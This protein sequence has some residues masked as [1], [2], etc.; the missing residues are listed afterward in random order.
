MTTIEISS[1]YAESLWLQALVSALPYIGGSV[2]K[3][4]TSRHDSIVKSRIEY[5][6]STMSDRIEKL[7]VDINKEVVLTEEFHDIL[8]N[9]LEKVTKIGQKERIKAISSILVEAAAGQSDLDS[10][11]PTDLINVLAEL[12]DQEALVLGTVININ[13]NNKNVMTGTNNNL[14]KLD[15]IKDELPSTLKASADF[16]CSRLAGKGLLDTNFSYFSLSFAG[17]KIKQ[18]LNIRAV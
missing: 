3:L 17:I 7:E 13:F 18:Y 15:N 4:L 8:V 14:M 9:S 11:H 12:T 1:K 6:L 16:L 5:L 2:D 10:V